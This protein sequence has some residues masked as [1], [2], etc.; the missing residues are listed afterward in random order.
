MP[1]LQHT[2]NREKRVIPVVEASSKKEKDSGRTFKGRVLCMYTSR[3]SSYL[4]QTA[5][6]FKTTTYENTLF[7]ECNQRWL[8][9]RD[10]KA[11]PS[12]LSTQTEPFFRVV[13]GGR[14]WQLRFWR[15]PCLYNTPHALWSSQLLAP[16]C[17]N[18]MFVEG[19]YKCF[20]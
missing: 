12:S 9:C 16:M 7:E 1:L 6:L 5:H 20:Q 3:F 4:V 13:G 19:C 18:M 17:E 2:V 8:G 14:R 10:S 11:S 15:G